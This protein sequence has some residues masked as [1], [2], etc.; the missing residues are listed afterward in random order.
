MNRK[1]EIINLINC[2]LKIR[3]YEGE[4]EDQFIA[5]VIYSALGVWI[6]TVTLDKEILGDDFAEVGVSKIHINNRCKPF[7]DNMIEIFPSTRKWFYP[8]GNTRNPISITRERL[9]NIQEIINSGFATSLA[10]P[11]YNECFVEDG[12]ILTRGMK[13]DNSL[14]STGLGQIKISKKSCNNMD[15]VF[16]F[17]NIENKISRDIIE[18]YLSVVK[19]RKIDEFTGEIFDIYSKKS[20]S[21]SWSTDLKLRNNEVSLYKYGIKDFG[22]IKM[23]EEEIYMC[24]IDTYLIDKYEIRRFMYVFRENIGNKVVAKYKKYEGERVVKLRLFNALP[25]KELDIIMLLG[26]PIRNI[27]DTNNMIFNE[28]VWAI[29]S[30]ILTNLGIELE[31]EINE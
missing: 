24:Q 14:I 9:F 10:L 12:V 8:E 30:E 4:V 29:V 11:S 1:Y 6:R 21:N 15:S 27:N 23:I 22:L 18:Q 20:F 3:R 19:W 31:E 16:A 13:K 25:Q 2:D 7:L 17:Y 5:R 28:K 26:W